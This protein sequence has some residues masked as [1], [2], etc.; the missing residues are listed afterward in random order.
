MNPNE[1]VAGQSDRQSLP[2][3]YCKLL[4]LEITPITLH[5]LLSFL[6]S[7][8]STPDTRIV[9]AHNLHSA[10][11]FHTD[12]EFRS[13]YRRADIILTDGAP[14][15]WDYKFSKGKSENHRMGSTDWIPKLN[16]I[17]GLDRV[18]VVGASSD[19][20]RKFVAWLEKLLPHAAVQGI[21]GEGWNMTKSTAAARLIQDFSPQ[22]ILIGIGMPR[23]ELF[24]DH[25]KK[26]SVP[27]VISTI[28]GAIDQLAG[29]QKNAPRWTGKLG[30]EWLWRLLTQPTRLWRRYLIEPWK[31]LWVRL[32]RRHRKHDSASEK[33]TT[34]SD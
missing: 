26:A 18:S 25:L 19:S 8:L 32:L 4:G 5:G 15:Q 31:L 14:V 27:A 24:A 13:F 34:H 6:A 30:I 3:H 11:L 21:P 23:Q 12:S 9:A 33:S 10:Y 2:S 16:L 28:G 29:V 7:A 22:L 20:N 17:E 1:N